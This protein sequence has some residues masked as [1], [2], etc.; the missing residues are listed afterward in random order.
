MSKISDKLP[1]FITDTI[2]YVASSI[3]KKFTYEKEDGTIGFK[4][5]FSKQGIKRIYKEQS[6]ETKCGELLKKFVGGIQ[7]GA[8]EIQNSLGI[9]SKKGRLDVAY[10]AANNMNFNRLEFD[11]FRN[12][13]KTT[14]KDIEN[15]DRNFRQN[16]EYSK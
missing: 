4:L 2:E 14:Q 3:F 8:K 13:L 5:P 12:M 1:S 10:A 7:T 16:E 6:E 15:S 9:Y 11:N